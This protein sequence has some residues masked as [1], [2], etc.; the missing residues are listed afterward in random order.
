MN[1]KSKLSKKS[2]P[3]SDIYWLNGIFLILTP[4]VSLIGIPLH[5]S[6]FGFSWNNVILCA[7]F[8][9][10][11]GLS[12]TGGYHRLFA[13]KS[14]EASPLVKIL[15]LL[16]GAAAFQ[17][18]VVKWCSDHRD[19]HRYVDQLNDPYSIQKGFFFAHIGWVF[20]KDRENSFE[21][22]KDLRD[23]KW[24]WLQHRYYFSIAAFMG[25]GV[26]FL[27]GMIYGDPWGGLLWGGF[28][29][30]VLVHHSTF[31]INSLSHYLGKRPYSLHS[32]AR[33]NMLTALL[34][35]GEGYHNYHHEFQFD[36]RN[37]I[38][39]YQ[40]DPTKW[41]IKLLEAIRFV[42]KL[43]RASDESIFK[44]RILVE[45]ERV[46]QNINRISITLPAS[47]EQ[48]LNQAHEKLLAA[49]IRWNRMKVE[50][51]NVK[52]SLVNRRIEILNKLKDDLESSQNQL[53][54]AYAA[55]NN[56]M[57]EFYAVYGNPAIL[58][59]Y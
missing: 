6:L 3:E 21:N 54:E 56:L 36:Y 46:L 48:R 47:L 2:A 19:H 39:W 37:G 5:L 57:L 7:L 10:A 23:D 32:S 16:F 20:L 53:K 51:K 22:V 27:L 12:I 8:F 52:R 17:K 45:R 40:W 1:N 25:F 43:R 14:Y 35:F 28:F 38:K 34:T 55:W 50:Y 33:D 15:F 30:T 41:M 58:S 9:A 26:P 13:H 18:S 11:T 29:R 31:L 49:G 24:I 59:S 42:R 44:A 4:L